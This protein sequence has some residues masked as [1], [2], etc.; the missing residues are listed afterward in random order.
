MNA[1]SLASQYVLLNPEE[2][3]KLIMAAF[4]RDDNDELERLTLAGSSKTLHLADHG[5]YALAFLDLSDVVCLDLTALAADYLEGILTDNTVRKRLGLKQGEDRCPLLDLTLAQGFELN[6]KLQGWE[7]FC[8]RLDL[9]PFHLW[10]IHRGYQ[11]IERARMSSQHM[12]FA[13]E[14]YH[15]WLNKHCSETPMF[16]T[17]QLTPEGV[18]DELEL[19]YQERLTWWKGSSF[20]HANR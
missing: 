3:F 18:A 13:P 14:G 19:I 4:S 9:P 1:K 12:A 7:C 20:S 17:N 15:R 2:R 6:L 8:A 10:Q 16:T 11:R 5:P